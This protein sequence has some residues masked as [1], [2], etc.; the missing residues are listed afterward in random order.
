[1]WAPMR[2]R[3]SVRGRR[4]WTPQGDG[5]ALVIIEPGGPGGGAGQ[6]CEAPGPG[7][8]LDFRDCL[9]LGFGRVQKLFV[10]LG[11]LHEGLALGVVDVVPDQ[12]GRHGEALAQ[13]IQFI[14]FRGFHHFFP[15]RHR[16]SRNG[17]APLFQFIL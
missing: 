5:L 4:P 10:A 2:R 6:G 17:G 1:M 15:P 8:P 13:K 11:I 14:F 3:P 9:P 7:H 16:L 12:P